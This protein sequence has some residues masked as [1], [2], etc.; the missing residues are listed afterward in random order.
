[1]IAYILRRLLIA[2]PLLL[3]IATLI[4]FVLSLAPGDPTSVYLN[5]NAPPEVVE[6]LRENLGLDR[7][8]PVRYAKWLGAFARGIFLSPP[9]LFGLLGSGAR[10]L[11]SRE[12]AGDRRVARID[13]RFHLGQDAAADDEEDHAQRQQQPEPLRL[14]DESQLGNLG[15]R[16]RF[17]V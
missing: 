17:T 11:G 8:L 2:I 12:V 14:I 4:F 3:G 16:V 13:R 5:P 6:Q 10:R 1:M 9:I 15:H 7:P